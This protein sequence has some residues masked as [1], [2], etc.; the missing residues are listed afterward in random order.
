[1]IIATTVVCADGWRVIATCATFQRG[2]VCRSGKETPTDIEA[3]LQFHHELFLL[4]LDVAKWHTA[5][6]AQPLGRAFDHK[7]SVETCLVPLG[8]YYDDP[9]FHEINHTPQK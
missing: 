1:M 4:L 2:T 6:S 8:C 9:R 3:Q 7:E 5:K